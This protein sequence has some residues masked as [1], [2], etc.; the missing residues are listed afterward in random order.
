[1]RLHSLVLAAAAFLIAPAW[2]QTQTPAAD[3]AVTAVCKD[4]T[5][6]SGKT[7]R[8]ACRGHGGVDKEAASGKKAE[9]APKAEAASKKVEKRERSE[10]AAAAAASAPARP[11]E[12][13]VNTQSK[14][15]HCAG[16]RYYGKTK[17][18]QY[19]SE[20]EA[21]AQGFHAAKEKACTAG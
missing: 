14:V 20:K 9:N 13:W 8:G 10:T 19:M 2:A 12:V 11:G 16:S 15:F 6:F 3:T 7:L 1:M 4:G 21:L 18:G 5:Q 17:Q